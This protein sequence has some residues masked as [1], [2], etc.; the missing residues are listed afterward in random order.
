MLASP[1]FRPRTGGLETYVEHLATGLAGEGHNVVVV[2]GDNV[3]RVRRERDDGLT[4]YRLPIWRTLS[5]TPVDPR[6]PWW[7]RRII[8]TEDPDVLNAHAPVV[9]MVDAVALVAG[10]RPF[11]VTWHAATLE[12]PAAPLLAAVTRGYGLAQRLTFRRADRIVAVSPYVQ[13]ALGRWSAKTRVVSNAVPAVGE[14]RSGAGQGLA[15]VA[16]LRAAHSWKG[17]DLLLDALAAC[18]ARFGSAPALTVMGDGDD[19]PR[20]ERRVAELGLAD[21]T[22]FAGYVAPAER[23]RLLR[24]ARAL[25]ACPVTANDAF[26][27][28]LL[29]AWA[30]GVPVVAS[31]IGPIPSLV[32]DGRTGLLVAPG[33]A[34]A[35]AAALHRIATED[36]LASE[37]GEAGRR[38]VQSRYTWPTQIARMTAVL[39]EL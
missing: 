34:D 10:R 33:D 30:Q 23:D 26:P 27:T 24:G 2:C 11:V 31:A 16:S 17:L 28:V 15:F 9:F 6:W 38:L 12:K 25:V 29:D 35:L 37:L 18:R 39:G 4:I 22:R 3:A 20:Y 21:G 32:D 1:Y 5:N 14:P 19:R 13:R 8:A 7:L 36:E